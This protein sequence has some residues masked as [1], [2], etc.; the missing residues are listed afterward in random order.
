MTHEKVE[1][2]IQDWIDSE[3]ENITY[4]AHLI[5]LLFNVDLME[6]KC[7]KCGLEMTLPKD[8]NPFPM[9]MQPASH[10]TAGICGGKIE[11][12]KQLSNTQ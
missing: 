8:S 5:C 9:C 11:E 3:N 7:D 1:K 10:R 12:I 4:L 6:V 2:V